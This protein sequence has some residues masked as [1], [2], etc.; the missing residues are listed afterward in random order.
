[1]VSSALPMERIENRRKEER[2]K[3]RFIK[4]AVVR[5]Y[6]IELRKNFR[7]SWK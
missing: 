4:K 7:T 6:L 2:I 1:M 3:R 5:K